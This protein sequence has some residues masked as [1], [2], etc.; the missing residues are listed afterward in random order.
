MNLQIASLNSGSNG[1][2]YYIG[3]SH[4]AV[5]ID[6]GISSREIEK[7]MKRLGL[8]LKKVKAVFITHEH[9]DHIIG[10]HRLV[11]RH[12]MPVY[13]TQNTRRHT[14]LTWT[15]NTGIHFEPHVPVSIGALRV[16]AIPKF[17]DAQDPHSFVVEHAGTRVGIFTDMGRV[18]RNLVNA[19]KTCHAAVL[20]ANYDAHLL[21]TGGYPLHLK[22]RI[23]G[24]HGHISNHQALQLFLEHRPPFM[25]HLFLGHL[26]KNNNRPELV[27]ELFHRAAGETQ[28]MIASR[29]EESAVVEVGQNTKS[30]KPHYVQISL[31]DAAVQ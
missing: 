27:E 11:K 17:H 4:E 20:E 30:R 19:F 8:S 10:L 13:I 12:S 7:R 18:C 5:L 23:R 6:A 3:N 31:F 14:L 24:G 22:E 25:S 29:Y 28:I 15:E 2:C 21:E 1:N 9:N 26:S 16:T